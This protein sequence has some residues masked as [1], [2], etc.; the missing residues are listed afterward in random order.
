MQKNRLIVIFFSNPFVSLEDRYF[1][2]QINPLPWGIF[3]IL[4]KFKRASRV[5]FCIEDYDTIF[6]YDLLLISLNDKIIGYMFQAKNE[7]FLFYFKYLEV[8]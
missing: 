8:L 2:L 7:M 1:H 6:H 4:A 3:T 5:L